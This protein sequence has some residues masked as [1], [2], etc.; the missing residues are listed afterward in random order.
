MTNVGTPLGSKNESL[1][2][3]RDATMGLMVSSDG[4]EYVVKLVCGVGCG[5]GV[6]EASLIPKSRRFLVRRVLNDLN[7][8]SHHRNNLILD[9]NIL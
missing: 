2:W 4:P 1:T 5:G 7:V 8:L 3:N 6:E 9:D